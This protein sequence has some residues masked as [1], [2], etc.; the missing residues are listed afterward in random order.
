MKWNYNRGVFDLTKT[1]CHKK[2]FTC[3]CFNNYLEIINLA[4]LPEIYCLI[5]IWEKQN[6]CEPERIPSPNTYAALRE[7]F[8]IF[9]SSIINLC[10]TMIN[11]RDFFFN[12]QEQLPSK[13]GLCLERPNF[14][15]IWL[16]KTCYINIF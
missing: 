10:L 14:A 2:M 11:Q 4:K 13:P 6:W 16:K 5:K 3:N 8:V 12:G 9:K 7:N 15:L 1:D